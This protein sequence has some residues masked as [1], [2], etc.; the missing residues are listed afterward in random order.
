M[1]KIILACQTIADELKLAIN[2]TGVDYP[3]LWVESGLHNYPERLRKRIQ[4]ELDRISN[5]STILVAFGFCGTALLG[6]KAKNQYRG[7]SRF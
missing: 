2:L 7:R 4:Q 5:V 1:S 6:V 3:V